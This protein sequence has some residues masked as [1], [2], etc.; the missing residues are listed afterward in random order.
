MKG[1][2]GSGNIK[3]R[4][5]W[6]TPQWLFDIL[7]KQYK[8]TFDCCANSHNTKVFIYGQD[9]LGINK[10]QLMSGVCWMNPP[11][12][13]VKEMFEH[14]FKVVNK[15]VAIYRCDNMETKI[16]QEIIFPHASWVFVFDKRI[17]YEG[18][19]GKGSRFPSA[20]IGYNVSTP[21][22]LEGHLLFIKN[23][24]GD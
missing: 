5:E 12:T 24:G 16:W 20:L 15:G 21:L 9:F 10:Q 8:F 7:H 4:D 14:F 22:N 3:S 19:S 1:N 13:K 23:K 2:N 17:S 18:M 6:R 11:F